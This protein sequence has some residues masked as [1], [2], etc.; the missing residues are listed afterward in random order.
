[1][2]SQ[3]PD[4]PFTGG[5]EGA[6]TPGGRLLS[7]LSEPQNPVKD[8]DLGSAPVGSGEKRLVGKPLALSERM[9]LSAHTE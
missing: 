5:Q 7:L 9:S 2:I 6:S 3:P 1:M 8:G 4:V